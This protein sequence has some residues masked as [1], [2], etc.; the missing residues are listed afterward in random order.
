MKVILKTEVENLGPYGTEVKVAPGYARNYLIPKGHAV[1]ATPGNRRQF[2]AEKDAYLKKMQ[3]KK[4]QAEK[5][6]AEIEA[7]SLAFTRKAAE[8]GRLFG[9]V[10]VH[11]IESELS[12]K[13]FK[14][15]RKDIRLEEPIKAV[16][17][18]TVKI[19]LHSEVIAEVKVAVAAEEEEKKEAEKE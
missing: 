15:E 9:S 16:G 7:V 3:A 1:E 17:E 12:S 4:E 2:N 5:R 11:D 6:K 19:K 10:T 18:S 8:D 13:G 14:I